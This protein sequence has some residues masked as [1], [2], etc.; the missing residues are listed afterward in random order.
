MSESPLSLN[1]VNALSRDDFIAAFGGVA[2]HSPWVA[3]QAADARPFASRQAMAE[4]FVE[5]VLTAGDPQKL[6]VVRAHPDLAGRAAIAGDIA[7]D[8]K[9]EQAG[10][11]LDRLT[12]H[13]FERF[14]TLNDAYRDRFRFPFILAVRGLDKHGILRAFEERIANDPE[15]ELANAVRQ[16]AQIVAFRINDRVSP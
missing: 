12:P 15:A 14:S 2:E 3:E 7:E 16:V 13:E 8:S 10:A 4:A 1:Q 9:H 5:A 6:A 11:G